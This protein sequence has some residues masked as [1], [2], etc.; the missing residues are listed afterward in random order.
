M[1]KVAPHTLKLLKG[2]VV[3]AP[4]FLGNVD[5]LFD[6]KVLAKVHRST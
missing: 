1:N 3:Y 4:Q 5:V 2:G 6:T